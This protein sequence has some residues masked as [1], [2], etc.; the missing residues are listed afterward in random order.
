LRHQESPAHIVGTAV[1]N[2]TP[3][4]GNE[5]NRASIFSGKSVLVTG[6]CG[7]LG[8]HIAK[9]LLVTDA[10]RIAICDINQG[11]MGQLD[12]RLN[13]SRLRFFVG[14]IRDK[15]RTRRAVEDCD[16]VFH[17]AA[18]KIIPSC[19]YNPTEA[20][21]TNI[22]GTQNLLEAC[23]DEEP[24]R[25]FAISTDKACAPLNLYGA[26]KLC[27]ERLIVTT[28]LMK[29]K[30]RTVFSCVRYGNVWG[31]NESVIPVWI[32]QLTAGQEITVTSPKMTRF[33]ITMD[34]AVEFIFRCLPK[35]SGGEVFIPKLRAYY[36]GD[37]VTALRE[38]LHVRFGVREIGLRPGE[39][40]HETL[41]SDH[42]ARLAY[43]IGAEYVILPDPDTRQR[44][45]L[46]YGFAQMTPLGNS[47]GIPYSSANAEK[48]TVQELKMLL[49][50]ERLLESISEI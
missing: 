1:Q 3:P 25:V 31:S 44:Y 26:T 19:E 35:A 42:E 12:R 41:I 45:D 37:L 22:I 23:L 32:E 20:I 30:R 27:M 8:S 29:G 2:D 50:K 33:S 5:A 21:R 16:I 48:M 6:G 11:A 34:Q 49:T 24:E 17:C 13:D 46:K 15:D 18:L 43:D 10:R 9:A 47:G 39:K 7:S 40:E 14:D 38:L 28:N 36:V 4:K